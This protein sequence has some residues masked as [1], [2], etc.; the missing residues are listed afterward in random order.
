MM[1]M[2]SFNPKHLPSTRVEEQTRTNS[3]TKQ[4]QVEEY[5]LRDLSISLLYQAIRLK[6]N[7]KP[8]MINIALVPSI[9]F[10]EIAPF[11]LAPA[12]PLAVGLEPEPDVVVV[13]VAFVA[14]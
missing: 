9:P 12:T 10:I 5:K 7:P 6:T 11:E 4:I 8:V 3:R 13:L 14:N 1:K 2:T